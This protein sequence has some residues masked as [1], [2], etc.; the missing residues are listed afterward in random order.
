[1]KLVQPSL[2]QAADD[3]PSTH[4]QLEQLLPTHNAVLPPCKPLHL[5]LKNLSGQLSTNTVPN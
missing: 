2:L 1:M 4:P 5:P 3:S